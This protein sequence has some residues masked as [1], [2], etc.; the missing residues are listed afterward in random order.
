[1]GRR[2]GGERVLGPYRVGPG[3]W[4][5]EHRRGARSK[6]GDGGGEGA[7]RVYTFSDEDEAIGFAQQLR[8]DIGASAGAS[9]F[10]TAIAEY[11]KHLVAKG[12]K[13]KSYTETIRRMK[14]FFRPVLALRV[15]LLTEARARKLYQALVGKYAAD[16]HRN[17]LAEAKSFLRWCVKK[18]WLR[19][20]PLEGVEGQGRR[21]HGKEQHRINEARAFYRKA[22]ELAALG[23]EGAT[24]ALMAQL[25]ALRA[26][27][28]TERR[29][30][31]VDDDGRILWV[32]DSK[33]K[34]GRRSLET[35]E[36][37]VPI[38]A[39]LVK[40]RKADE[41]LFPAEG[42]SGHHWRDWIRKQVHRVARLAGV[43]PITAH[44]MRGTHASIA[45]EHGR[46]GAIVA[47]SLGHES[48]R[49]TDTA[50]ADRE[51]V[52]RGQRK[53]ALTVLEGGRK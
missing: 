36:P 7:R 14:V 19:S 34:A 3:K 11:E 17:M 29:V 37:L 41:W 43:K 28:I 15:D 47:A 13:P 5:V 25:F 32:P 51:A 18:R 31:D 24:A 16:S 21:S 22:H 50:Y 52:E 44:G 49:M 38:L 53:K 27:E 33:T 42:E 9:S 8:A 40:G 10:D 39:A 45:R 48:L 35:P 26:S 4:T 6:A 2:P 20:N 12:N 46:S 23:D 30:R 1:M